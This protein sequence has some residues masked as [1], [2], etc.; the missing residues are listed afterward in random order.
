MSKSA[1]GRPTEMTEPAA[2]TAL[3]LVVNG[4]AVPAMA[5]TLLALLGELGYQGRKVATAV[6]GAFVA[7]A[8]R[9]ATPLAAGDRI[10]ILAPRQGG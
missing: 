2:D 3:A 10:E 7:E 5:R 4:T 9:G 1:L 8:K 6:N